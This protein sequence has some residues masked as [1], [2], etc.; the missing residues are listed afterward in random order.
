VIRPRDPTPPIAGA[1]ASTTIVATT[2]C[3]AT[4]AATLISGLVRCL[5]RRCSRL[6]DRRLLPVLSCL[7]L[8]LLL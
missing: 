3:T 1:R 4:T 6:L 5:L 7:L 8:P 2:V